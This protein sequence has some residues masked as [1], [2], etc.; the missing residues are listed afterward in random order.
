MWVADVKKPGTSPNSIM[1][2]VDPEPEFAARLCVARELHM[3][4][5]IAYTAINVWALYMCTMCACV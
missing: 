1:C 3:W 5:H 4:V 2:D